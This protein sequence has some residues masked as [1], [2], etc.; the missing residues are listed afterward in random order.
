MKRILLQ[1]AVLFLLSNFSIA[2]DSKSDSLVA[3]SRVTSGNDLASTYIELSVQLLDSVPDSSLYYADQAEIILLK[4]DPDNLLPPLFKQKGKIY[5]ARKVTDRSLFYYRKA[6]DGFIRL[7]NQQEIGSCAL[8]LGNMYYELGDF[9]E[10]YY[11][12]MHSLNAYEREGDH[13]GIAKMENNLG[14]VAHEMGKLDEAEKH[15][16]KAYEIYTENGSVSDQCRSLNNIG[17]ILYDRKVYDSAL[18]YFNEAI[19]LLEPVLPESES[20]QHILSGVY[21]N[22][23]LAYSDLGEFNMALTYLRKGLSLAFQI[24]DLYNIGSVYVNLGAIFGKLDY[25]DS[26]LYYLHRS[27][28]ISKEM[29]FKHLELEV[30]DELSQLHAGIGSYASA[31]NWLLRYDTVYKNLFNENQSEQIARLRA[32][33][34]QEIKDSEIEQLHSESQVQRTLNKVFIVFIVVIVI[35]VIIITVNLRSK[36]ITNQMLAEQNLQIS[37]TNS[38]LS[39]SEK[40]LQRLNKSKDRIFTVVA[41]D[42]RNPVA[43]V[44]GFSELLYEN[45]EQFPVE[46]QKEYLLQIVQGS[47]RTQNLLE[48]L[49]V[50][51]RS[52]MKAIKFEPEE[53]RVK[54]LA[55]ECVKE[56]KA[57]LDYKK[58]RCQESIDENCKVFADKAMIHTVFRN[59]IMNAIKFSFPGGKIWITA[60]ANNGECIITISD[61]GIGIPPEIQEKLFDANEAVSTPGTTGESGS[62]LGLVICKEF[63]ERNRGEIRVESDA[64]NGSSFIVTLPVRELE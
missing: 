29:G 46:T 43:A 31:Y 53:L 28:R 48:N 27:L 20:E 1:I 64:G 19:D 11:F 40:E 22:I 18:V 52:Q 10:A 30:Y 3:I 14:T 23:A 59:I 41:H 58:V 32:R 44:T 15:Y 55:A 35:L 16:F 38:R 61:E 62:G 50:W 49:L 6:Y 21:N 12:Y 42:L 34:E 39:E 54:N 57:N 4:A 56:L 25:Q 7:E 17:L 33:Y 26:A 60:N 13:M 36:K 24:D 51:A 45:F 2:Q 5:K 63:L 47:Q 9:S 8:I 37:N